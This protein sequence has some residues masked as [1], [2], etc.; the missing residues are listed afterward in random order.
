MIVICSPDTDVAVISLNQAYHRS[1]QLLFST[2]TGNRKRVL[3]I[4][5]M[6]QK[7]GDTAS[8]AILGLHAL[9]GSDT[10]SCFYGKGK[11]T[12]YSQLLNSKE[13]IDAFAQF[14][15]NLECDDHVLTVLENYVCK[16]YGCKSEKVNDARYELFCTATPLEK[17]LPPNQ[18]ALFQHIKR[19]CYQAYIWRL[20]T[21]NMMNLPSPMEHGWSMCDGAIGIVW[22]LS[23]PAP[24][25]ILKLTNCH[26]KASGCQGRCSCFSSNMKCTSLCG[27]GT[28]CNNRGDDDDEMANGEE[29]VETDDKKN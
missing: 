17:A 4:T 29:L 9:T 20:S 15:A 25:E 16:L 27:C 7:L 28:K 23:P 2:G 11:R 3:D 24:P 26:C 19:A 21:R 13:F 8:Q 22:L 18:D 10:V 1:C 12:C 5:S 6:A 14:G